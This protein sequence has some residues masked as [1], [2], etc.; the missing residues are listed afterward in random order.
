MKIIEKIKNCFSKIINSPYLPFYAMFVV[1]LFIHV[2]TYSNSDDDFFRVQLDQRNLID[3]L[4]MR[5]NTWSSRF[6][7]EVLFV[8]VTRMPMI[9][10]RFFDSFMFSILAFLISKIFNSKKNIKFDWI[11]VLLL[12]I[13]PFNDMASAG[14]ICTTIPY[15]W[16]TVALL[17]V[18]YIFKKILT[19]NN[20]K[21]HE[22]VLMYISAF[23]TISFEQT[24]CLLL[25]FNI[26]F[27]AYL[28]YKKQLDF[29]E[30]K[31]LFIV[32]FISL[33]MLVITLT[34]PGNNAR[35]LAEVKHWYPQYENYGLLSKLYLGIV[36]TFEIFLRNKIVITLFSFLL[37][38]AAF[39]KSDKNYV[40]A[41]AF[42]QFAFFLMFGI[43][44]KQ[45][46]NIFPSIE[47]FFTIVSL[48]D[49]I[50]LKDASFL[51]LS[52]FLIIVGLT[53]IISY[54]LYRIFDD[55]LLPLI[56]FGAS[57]A[58]RVMMGFS[59]TIF[60]SVDRTA[61]FMYIGII[62]LSFMLFKYIYDN[63]TKKDL[64]KLEILDYSLICLVVINIMN[65]IYTL[66]IVRQAL[67]I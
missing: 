24:L 47:R 57:L 66:C 34:C 44:E 10:W 5:Y 65:V 53:I 7:V 27:L 13:Y 19:K 29:K 38:V 22:Y 4:V 6:L 8:T 23:L 48:K 32:L 62:I 26:V 61:F 46:I 25:G 12:L 37:T 49:A 39:I 15:V 51:E 60:A 9:I 54:L 55:N 16:T 50:H 11:I 36:P 14:Y 31:H 56:I 18:M 17:Y 42:L 40:R 64:R 41:L 43:F 2:F 21:K 45:L 58:S 67:G 20:V 30:Y 1:M 28:F 33:I 3:Y 59:P 35:Y 63:V 52:P